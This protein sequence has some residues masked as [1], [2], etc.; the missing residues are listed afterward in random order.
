[1]SELAS[2]GWICSMV[3]YNPPPTNAEVVILDGVDVKEAERYPKAK[4]VRIVDEPGTYPCDLLVCGGA[5]A[6]Q[7]GLYRIE[8]YNEKRYIVGGHNVLAGPEY[9]LLRPEF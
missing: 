8:E 1:M 7:E 9:A 5:W 3:P 2:R 4:L 6:S